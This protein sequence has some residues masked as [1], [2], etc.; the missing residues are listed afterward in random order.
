LLGIIETGSYK[1]LAQAG[2]K[3]RSSWFLPPEYVLF[4]LWKNIHKIYYLTFFCDNEVWTQGLVLAGQL[5][6][7]KGSNDRHISILDERG[8]LKA[9]IWRVWETTGFSEK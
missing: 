2:F 1:L 7:C 3:L 5:S 8:T 4:L 9:D 6:S